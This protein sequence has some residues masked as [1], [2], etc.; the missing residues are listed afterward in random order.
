MAVLLNLP[1]QHI[2]ITACLSGG[3]LAAADEAG[4]GTL[5]VPDGLAEL[6]QHLA[7]VLA[8]QCARRGACSELLL[9][10]DTHR[11]DLGAD[12]GLEVR[13]Q[14]RLGLRVLGAPALLLLESASQLRVHGFLRN[15]HE[16]PRLVLY[17][18]LHG[19]VLHA[20]GILQGFQPGPD[21]HLQGVDA[22]AEAF[23]RHRGGH[24]GGTASARRLHLRRSARSAGRGRGCISAGQRPHQRA[25]APRG[26]H[27]ARGHWSFGAAKLLRLFGEGCQAVAGR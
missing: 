8:A 9:H 18:S 7:A 2:I 3:L 17:Q 24:R 4:D 15:I 20:D 23:G 27:G 14:L 21:V 11:Q 22:H 5:E 6:L 13:T 19:V 10:L 26:G 1:P 25:L 12:G 16:H